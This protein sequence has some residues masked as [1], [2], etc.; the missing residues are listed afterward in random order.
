MSITPESIQPI[1]IPSGVLGETPAPVECTETRI[2]E[3]SVPSGVNIRSDASTSSDIVP[4]SEMPRGVTYQ[5]TRLDDDWFVIKD[6]DTGE[7]RYVSSSVVNARETG[8][9]ACASPVSTE[10]EG[11]A[12]EFDRDGGP[13]WFE[14]FSEADVVGL[15]S[16]ESNLSIPV[17]DGIT[18]LLN[19][20]N[21]LRDQ[22][23]LDPEFADTELSVLMYAVDTLDGTG[24]VILNT[25]VVSGNGNTM[26]FPNQTGIGDSVISLS[27]AEGQIPSFIPDT[28]RNLIPVILDESGEIPLSLLQANQNGDIEQSID[29][30]ALV[31][32]EI[33]NVFRLSGVLVVSQDD[34]GDLLL[35][36]NLEG[37]ESIPETNLGYSVKDST[38]L[39]SN[40]FDRAVGPD[41]LRVATRIASL[42]DTIKSSVE[43][44]VNSGEIRYDFALEAF[45]TS[46]GYVIR[47]DAIPLDGNGYI[48]GLYTPEEALEASEMVLGSTLEVNLGESGEKVSF[49]FEN[50]VIYGPLTVNPVSLEAINDFVQSNLEAFKEYSG[51]TFVIS[52]V[53]DIDVD[54]LNHKTNNSNVAINQ[55][56]GNDI[57]H[58]GYSFSP[59]GSSSELVRIVTWTSIRGERKNDSSF[60][61]TSVLV[62]IASGNNLQ[63]ADFGRRSSNMVL[64]GKDNVRRFDVLTC[65]MAGLGTD[66][67]PCEND[68]YSPMMAAKEIQVSVIP[69]NS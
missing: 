67:S 25:V 35:D 57:A 26:Y 31:T 13:T 16:S 52:L 49:I 5:A 41:D 1:N 65:N 4:N 42:P 19:S 64:A 17:R 53:T 33:E 43:A 24:D 18:S 60:G 44:G 30:S 7:E 66:A 28:D 37:T 47:P 12:A 21:E 54:M 22:L 59:V 69:V 51:K 9:D 6:P 11:S 63:A 68:P 46:D 23:K 48:H 2:Y 20:S 38:N 39:T 34:D 32:G 62:A 29:T 45:V 15:T 14:V 55:T 3:V 10:Q 58:A 40:I 8:I 27:A 61:F 50:P 56:F 36:S